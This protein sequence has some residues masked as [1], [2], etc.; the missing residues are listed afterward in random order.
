MGGRRV[1]PHAARAKAEQSAPRRAAP[2]RA[3]PRERT[4][5]DDR[6]A[7]G[8]D[9]VVHVH[10]VHVLACLS[11]LGRRGKK[12]VT[13]R[14]RAR[15]FCGTHKSTTN[16]R[17]RSRAHT[18]PHRTYASKQQRL[19]DPDPFGFVVQWGERRWRRRTRVNNGGGRASGAQHAHTRTA[20][21]QN[22]PKTHT[23]PS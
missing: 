11:W 9:R 6:D 18:Q 15:R 13:P 21:T 4:S 7:L 2:R 22:T 16:T 10:E 17:A 5:D 1:A 19:P 23:R 12:H 14:A 8:N 20:N 3:A